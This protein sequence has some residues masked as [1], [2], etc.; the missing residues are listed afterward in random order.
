MEAMGVVHDGL[1]AHPG[2][3]ELQRLSNQVE[4]EFVVLK[5]P[6]TAA[7]VDKMTEAKRKAEAKKRKQADRENVCRKQV[8]LAQASL[9]K[10]KSAFAPKA[11]FCA[12][13]E[14]INFFK[15]KCRHCQRTKAICEESRPWK[16]RLDNA[17]AR[18]NKVRLSADHF[19]YLLVISFW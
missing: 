9:D 11:P 5:T 12:Q 7:V 8:Q 19:V 18:Y 10:A 6:D 14:K 3:E 13:Y 4:H 16:K 1:A 2:H 17:Q 15:R